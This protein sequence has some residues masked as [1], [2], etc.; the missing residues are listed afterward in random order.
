MRE[1]EMGVQMDYFVSA[2][3]M[4]LLVDQRYSLRRDEERIRGILI[5]GEIDFCPGIFQQ[6]AAL[7]C[8]NHRTFE[9]ALV[10]RR[11]GRVIF[12]IF[13]RLM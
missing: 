6:Q 3:V 4:V 2:S 7:L 12:Q 5:E 13:H 11:T 1:A 8:E 10:G 9:G